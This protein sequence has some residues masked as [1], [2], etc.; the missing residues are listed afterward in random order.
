[1]LKKGCLAYDLHE[2]GWPDWGI[3]VMFIISCDLL[4]IFS[5]FGLVNM[6]LRIVGVVLL[7]ITL[8]LLVKLLKGALHTIHISFITKAKNFIIVQRR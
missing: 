8:I 1:V 3:G 6:L 4:F 7:S 5:V 2:A